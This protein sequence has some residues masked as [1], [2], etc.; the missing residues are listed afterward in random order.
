VLLV[1]TL[2]VAGA[3]TAEAQEDESGE[4]PPATTAQ[5]SLVPIQGLLRDP[6]AKESIAPSFKDTLKGKPAF[7]RDAKATL[8]LRSFYLLRDKFDPTYQEAWAV[9]GS[10]ALKSGYLCD[11][12]AVGLGVYGSLPLYAPE[13]RDGTLLLKP[14]QEAYGVLGQLY[15]EVKLWPGVLLSLF[16]K[17]YN[18]PYINKNDNRM[19]PNSFEAYTV[20]GK[21]GGKDGA[22]EIV[23]GGGYFTRIKERNDDD[24][25]WMSHDAGVTAVDHGVAVAGGKWSTK[26]V[27]VGAVEYWCEDVLNILYAEGTWAPCTRGPVD[28]RFAGQFTDQRSTGDNLLTGASFDTQQVGL[29]AEASVGAV[30]AT[31]AY[32]STAS[33]SDMRNPWSSCPGYTS[34]QVQDF[35]RAGEQAFLAKANLDLCKAL[36]VPGVNVYALWVHGWDRVSG[37][38]ED[39]VDLDVQWR[40]GA[41]RWKAFSFRFRYAHVEQRDPGSDT[42]D[43]LRV[44]VN[45]DIQ[46]P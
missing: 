4:G 45:Y 28:L 35:N 27:S 44:I 17:E 31:L 36:G 14:G 2:L 37:S 39:E 29:K 46:L 18:T 24:F 1:A 38:N 7:F 26:Q 15:G 12:V 22:P 6:I 9:G 11:R 30:L 5:E 20:M 42:L 10:L 19:T 34:V 13:D 40:P 16:R 3:P 32:T 21:H 43:D 33:G 41:K 23:W 25:V 8:N